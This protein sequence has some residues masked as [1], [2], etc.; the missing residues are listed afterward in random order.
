MFGKLTEEEKYKVFYR[1][2]HADVMKRFKSLMK[3]RR[4]EPEILPSAELEFKKLYKELSYSKI[5]T[6]C[7]RV[8]RFCSDKVITRKMNRK[9]AERGALRMVVN[10]GLIVQEMVGQLQIQRLE[11]AEMILN[12]VLKVLWEKN[13]LF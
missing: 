11:I 12:G 6:L 1:C 4:L 13:S 9:V 7:D 8:A 2:L 10:F 5:I 3:A